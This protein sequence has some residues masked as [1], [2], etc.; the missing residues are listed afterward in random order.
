MRRAFRLPF[1]EQRASEKTIQ[2]TTK[3]TTT[4]TVTEDAGT[5]NEAMIEAMNEV[6]SEDVVVAAAAVVADEVEEEE[7]APST[8][9]L[10]P[11]LLE[12]RETSLPDH[13]VANI[14]I[15]LLLMDVSLTRSLE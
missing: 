7:I 3:E 6:M 10:H 15:N 13:V 4:L 9:M 8:K 14:I 12:V 1:V 11:D 5:M 2:L